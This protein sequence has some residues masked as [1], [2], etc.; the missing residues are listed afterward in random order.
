M[1]TT[2]QGGGRQKDISSG[3][4]CPEEASEH[5]Q[6]IN[7][8]DVFGYKDCLQLLS[9]L[10]WVLKQWASCPAD[11]R[12]VLAPRPGKFLSSQAQ[13]PSPPVVL[14][15]RSL[16]RQEAKYCS[17]SWARLHSL[18]MHMGDLGVLGFLG[19][20]TT[21][22]RAHGRQ[23]MR[24]NHPWRTCA[25]AKPFPERI[26]WMAQLLPPES[27][28]PAFPAGFFLPPLDGSGA[29]VTPLQASRVAH[30]STVVTCNHWGCQSRDKQTI[31]P[32]LSNQ[33]SAQHRRLNL[34]GFC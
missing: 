29:A 20:K 18:A 19:K 13:T 28:F 12:A 30:G 4:S 10:Q 34:Q 9:S 6:I 27:S 2:C 1:L 22:N 7:C 31:T 17:C 23:K 25:Q 26:G 14:W 33:L 3:K 16:S 21:Q 8:L 15:D 11:S 32:H 5:Y 24:T